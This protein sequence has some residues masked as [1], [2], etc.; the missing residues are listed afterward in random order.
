MGFIGVDM[1]KEKVKVDTDFVMQVRKLVEICGTGRKAAKHCGI[2]PELISTIKNGR[3]KLLYKNV[4]DRIK[5]LFGK[6][7]EEI[8]ILEKEL[9]V[10]KDLKAAE[11]QKIVSKKQE[12]MLVMDK[13]VSDIKVGK[14]YHIDFYPDQKGP[15]LREIDEVDGEVIEIYERFFLVQTKNFKVT[16]L[17]KEVRYGLVAMKELKN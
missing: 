6:N 11:N 10:S 7:L 5:G 14:R 1:A 13:R 12:D 3:T 4:Y 17:K 2:T 15:K 9:K 16:V 8:E